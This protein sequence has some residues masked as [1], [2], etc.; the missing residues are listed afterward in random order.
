MLLDKQRWHRCRQRQRIVCENRQL[1]TNSNNPD[2]IAVAATAAGVLDTL[3]GSII[4]RC[5]YADPVEPHTVRPQRARRRLALPT[6]HL[7][8]PLAC[9]DRSQPALPFV[10]GNPRACEAYRQPTIIN[11]RSATPVSSWASLEGRGFFAGTAI[12]TIAPTVKWTWFRKIQRCSQEGRRRAGAG[13]GRQP[14][15]HG[16][17]RHR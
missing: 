6:L 13:P 17:S 7:F 9:P 2:D 1:I 15:R 5:S 4:D 12:P 10:T 14:V 8:K 16:E 3:A 11:R